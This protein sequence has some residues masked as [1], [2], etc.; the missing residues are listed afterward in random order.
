MVENLTLKDFLKKYTAISN[1]FIDEY[2]SFYEKTIDNK[3]GIKIHDII[4]YLNIT[5]RHKFEERIRKN[6]IINIDYI[7]IKLSEKLEKGKIYSNY[8][9]SFEC[10]EKIC[11]NSNSEKGKLFRDYF[12]MLRKFIDYYK[13][14]F[15]NKIN[16]LVNDNKYIY[17]LSVNKGKNIFKLGRTKNIRN[18]LKSYETGKETHPDIKF[19]LIVK[20]EIKVEKC[21]KLISKQFK[22]K[23]NKELYKIEL[24]KLKSIIFN[25]SD[26]NKNIKD[27]I[28]NSHKYDYYIVYDNSKKNKNNYIN[29]NNKKTKKLDINKKYDINYSKIIKL[30]EKQSKKNK[31]LF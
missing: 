21:V 10:F 17:I 24:D 30:S 18:R 22:Y 6:Y 9:I 23:Q 20:D 12:V 25:C 19:I 8:F 16:E 27:N 7:I 31:K 13:Q 2:Y 1:K 5:N 14:H 11:M 3:F 26:I 15:S 29:S 4:K 28:N